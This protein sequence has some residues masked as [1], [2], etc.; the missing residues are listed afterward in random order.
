MAWHFD[1]IDHVCTL[2]RSPSHLVLNQFSPT[3]DSNGG[4][5]AP[6]KL[7]RNHHKWHALDGVTLN[8][9]AHRRN[10]STPVIQTEPSP[11]RLEKHNTSTVKHSASTDG[12]A[13]NVWHTVPT[14]GHN[15]ST[16]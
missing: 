1:T 16:P 7:T 9:Q 5:G 6:R 15:M 11:Q 4:E 12:D 2:R 3:L 10:S 13:L 14:G 8:V